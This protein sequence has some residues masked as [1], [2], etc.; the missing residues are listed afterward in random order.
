MSPGAEVAAVLLKGGNCELIFTGAGGWEN[1][2]SKGHLGDPP[3]VDYSL[4]SLVQ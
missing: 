3:S 2:P 4:L 1:L